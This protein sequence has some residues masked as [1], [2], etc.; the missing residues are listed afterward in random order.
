MY[1]YMNKVHCI[2]IIIYYKI[3]Y[4]DHDQNSLLVNRRNDNHSPG[5]DLGISPY[6]Q[7][8]KFQK[9]LSYFPFKRCLILT[10]FLSWK[11]ENVNL[12]RMV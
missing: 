5:P 3:H 7:P 10:C 6:R 1:E 11:F 4:Q 8:A 9:M 2:L 12:D